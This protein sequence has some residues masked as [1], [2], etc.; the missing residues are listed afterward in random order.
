MSSKET[1]VVSTAQRV[2]KTSLIV[3][4]ILGCVMIILGGFSERGVLNVSASVVPIVAIQWS[5]Y[6]VVRAKQQAK[7]GTS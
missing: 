7:Q 5:S 3:S 4:V 6:L 2:M 1:P